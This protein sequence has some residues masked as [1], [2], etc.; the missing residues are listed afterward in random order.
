MAFVMMSATS[1]CT[2]VSGGPANAEARMS[3]KPTIDSASGTGTP[4][5]RAEPRRPSAI[6]SLVA[7]MA[8]G[9][10]GS[11][12]ERPPA[13][14]GLS[15]VESPNA[16]RVSSGTCRRRQAGAATDDAQAVLVDDRARLQDRG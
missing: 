13:H 5:A 7:K 1:I 10:A 4:S 11:V 3:S 9:G 6:R 16:S 14:A 12:S 8:V 2:V 15:T